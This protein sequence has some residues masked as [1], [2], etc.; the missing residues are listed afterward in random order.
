MGFWSYNKHMLRPIFFQKGGCCV[1]WVLIVSVVFFSIRNKNFPRHQQISF[2][3]F[4][5]F[6]INE[7]CFTFYDE[8]LSQKFLSVSRNDVV[9]LDIHNEAARAENRTIY[10]TLNKWIWIQC[11]RDGTNMFSFVSKDRLKLVNEFSTGYSFLT[12]R[13]FSRLTLPA[14]VTSVDYKQ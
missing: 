6:P 2:F 14:L 1:F 7:C 9:D 3:C 10:S 5:Q 11:W 12:D 8:L 13:A 4:I